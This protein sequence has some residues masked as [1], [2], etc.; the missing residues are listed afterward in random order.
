MKVFKEVYEKN[1]SSS[2]SVDTSTQEITSE[3]GEAIE[4]S[5]VDASENVE[6]D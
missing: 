3:N 1:K 2:Q 4:E 5:S 6:E